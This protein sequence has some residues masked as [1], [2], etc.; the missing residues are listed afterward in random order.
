MWRNKTTLPPCFNAAQTCSSSASAH[1]A[2]TV[3]KPTKQ[4]SKGV[5]LL[6]NLLDIGCGPIGGTVAAGSSMLR[7]ARFLGERNVAYW[8]EAGLPMRDL[9]YVPCLGIG[10]SAMKRREFITIVG[11]AAAA[12]PVTARAQQSERMRRIGI[13]MPYPPSDTEWKSRVDALQQELQRLGWN[14]GRNIEFDERWTT[15]NLELVRANAA[16]LRSRSLTLWLPSAAG[17]FR[18]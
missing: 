12:W 17:S 9:C 18:S 11:V 3:S 16:G 8:H 7:L 15:D 2:V 6:F 1:R 4:I 13:L 14:R 10:D 5:V